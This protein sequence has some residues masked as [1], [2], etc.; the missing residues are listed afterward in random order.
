MAIN[1]TGYRQYRYKTESCSKTATAKALLLRVIETSKST[2]FLA[3]YPPLASRF[4][5]KVDPKSHT[6]M[7]PSSILGKCLHPQI[8]LLKKWVNNFPASKMQLIESLFIS[9]MLHMWRQEKL[10]KVDFSHTSGKWIDSPTPCLEDRCQCVVQ[11]F[12]IPFL[13]ILHQ[14]LQWVAV[15]LT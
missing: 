1:S 9:L 4:L 11:C 7:S 12:L 6:R 15:V 13:H 14:L 3:S 10:G 5:Q 8:F 2:C